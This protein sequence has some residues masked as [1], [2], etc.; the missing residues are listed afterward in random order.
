METKQTTQVSRITQALETQ[1]AKEKIINNFRQ[2]VMTKD[3]EKLTVAQICEHADV[4]R[5]TFYKY[6][7]DKYDV[8]EQIVLINI[9]QP[10]VELKRL[11]ASHDLP[12]T[13]IMEWFYQKIYEDRYFYSRIN[14]YTGKNS[15]QDFILIHTSNI[16]RS[17]IENRRLSE[18]DKEYWI[19]F[20][21]SSHAMLLIKWIRDGMT[22]PPKTMANYYEMWTIPIWKELYMRD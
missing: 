4:S 10:F 15:F 6:F 13:M 9:T 21:A 7:Q 22:V 8:I 2:L 1:S 19:Y 20:Y 11:Y 18:V 12:S 17:T 5:K 16:I 14:E 3:F